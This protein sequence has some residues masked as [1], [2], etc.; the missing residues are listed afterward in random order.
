MSIISHEQLIEKDKCFEN[1]GIMQ[2]SHQHFVSS[3]STRQWFGNV[4][5]KQSKL[6]KRTVDTKIS[7]ATIQTW[8]VDTSCRICE[9]SYIESIWSQSYRLDNLSLLLQLCFI[10][11]RLHSIFV[12]SLNSKTHSWYKKTR[13]MFIQTL[14][15]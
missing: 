13:N 8:F 2:Q 4:S 7:I 3:N 10:S 11:V 15:W 1:P 14:F 5:N 9:N 6:R 12:K